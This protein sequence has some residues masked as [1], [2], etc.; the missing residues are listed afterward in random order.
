M[1]VNAGHLGTVRIVMLNQS[2]ASN[3]PDF[4]RRVLATG[5]DAGAVWMKLDGVDAGRVIRIRLYQLT[6]REV[7]QLDGTIVRARSN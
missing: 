5:S 2:V 1:P 4:C 6:G 7:D 3:V